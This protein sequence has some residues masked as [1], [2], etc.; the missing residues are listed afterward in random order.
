[1]V[2]AWT[3]TISVPDLRAARGT[4]ARRRVI[5]SFDTGAVAAT[6]ENL[7]DALA[8][9]RHAPARDGILQ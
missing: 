8:R 1:M 6:Y 5:E 9:G 3:Q 7:Y 4:L 2:D